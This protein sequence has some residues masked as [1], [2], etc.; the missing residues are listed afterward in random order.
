M[1]RPWEVAVVKHGA[2]GSGVREPPEM[3]LARI[4]GADAGQDPAVPSD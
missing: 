4:R 1:K 3:G 2:R